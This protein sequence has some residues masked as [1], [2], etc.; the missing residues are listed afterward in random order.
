MRS[1]GK[2]QLP[3]VRAALLVS[4]DDNWWRSPAGCTNDRAGMV[5]R[6]RLRDRTLKV[7]GLG[8]LDLGHGYFAESG[9]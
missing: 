5:R 4:P 9:Q 8:L 7:T 1:F 6:V 3:R 2:G